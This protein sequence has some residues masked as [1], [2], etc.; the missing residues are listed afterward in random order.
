LNKIPFSDSSGPILNTFSGGINNIEHQFADID[1]DGDYDLIYLDS[2]GTYGWYENNGN[3]FNPHFILSFDTIPGMKFADWFYLV[4]IDDDGDLDIFT[5]GAAAFIEFRRNTGSPASPFFTLEID[6]VLDSNGDYIFSEFGSNPVFVDIDGDGDYDFLSGNSIGTVTFYENIGNNNSFDFKF[7]TNFW[8]DILIIGGGL[9]LSSQNIISEIHSQN[10]INSFRHGASSLD[11]ADIDNDGD[12]DLFWGDFFSRSL[13]FIQNNGTNTDPVM[14]L[15]LRTYPPNQDSIWTSG[16]NMPRFIDIDGD[17]DLDMFVSVLYNPTAPQSLMFYKNEGTEQVPDFLKETDNYLKT[18]DA[19][20]Q[21]YPAFIDINSDGDLDLFIGC[22]KFAGGTLHFFE[23]IGTKNNP[24]FLLIDSAYAGIEREL[25][26]S[27]AFGDLDNDGDYDL[28]VGEFLGRISYYENTGDKFSPNFIFHEQIKDNS[29]SFITAGNIARPFLI[30]IDNDGDLDLVLGGFNGRIT[31]YRNIGTPEDYIF[32]RDNLYFGNL[33]V[34]DNSAP[35][36]ID[37]TNDGKLELFSGS[38]SLSAKNSGNIFYYRND[39]SINQ[40]VW[41]LVEGK[42]LNQSFGS[43][44]VPFFVDIDNDGDLDLFI[45]NVKGGLYYFENQLITGIGPDEQPIP[46]FLLAEA[47]P[48]PFNSEITFILTTPVS[49]E[50]T[51]SVYNILGQKVKDLY[52]GMITAGKN[53]F[54]W[55]GKNERNDYLTSG[56]YFVFIKSS[57]RNTLLK[58]I[59]LK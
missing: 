1:N 51:I 37:Y 41:N 55:D 17:N 18:L 52:Y 31:L 32:E 39:G 30:D 6:T 15:L 49:E 54:Y 4:D 14:E 16:F 28:L 57:E 42:F 20:I 44:A 8:Q 48:N 59:Y 10:P 24:S 53:I 29:G 47:Y 46:S 22:A 35:F 45:G 27:P 19:G 2:D 58:I 11:F 23:N 5:G 9:K 3:R 50:V 36:L 33:D 7:I 26:I 13:Y 40:P 25:N 56:S 34:G 38:D 12:Y 43:D 21:S